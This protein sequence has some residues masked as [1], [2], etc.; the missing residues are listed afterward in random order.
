MAFNYESEFIYVFDDY[1]QEYL[2]GDE[3]GLMPVDTQ[4]GWEPRT[5]YV[6]NTGLTT[7]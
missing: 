4:E 2:T 5:V 1:Q 3:L 6:A 7:E